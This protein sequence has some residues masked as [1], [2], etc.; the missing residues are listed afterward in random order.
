MVPKISLDFVGI[1][2]H[3]YYLPRQTLDSGLRERTMRV[4]T[5]SE[6]GNKLINLTQKGELMYE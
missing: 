3:V 2:E 1:T 4:K 6:L 5:V